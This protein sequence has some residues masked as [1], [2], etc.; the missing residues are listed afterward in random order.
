MADSSED[1]SVTVLT[2]LTDTQRLNAIINGMLKEQKEKKIYGNCYLNAASLY[3]SINLNNLGDP[4]FVVGWV[5]NK[6]EINHNALAKQQRL[7][8]LYHGLDMMDMIKKLPVFSFAAHCWVEMDGEILDA[9]YDWAGA[10]MTY[11]RDY[12]RALEEVGHCL[13]GHHRVGQLFSA[14]GFI[15][16][17]KKESARLTPSHYDKARKEALASFHGYEDYTEARKSKCILH[18][19]RFAP[20]WRPT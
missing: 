11:F 14:N 7:R 3:D 5:L 10:G 18:N 9:S 6:N 17:W 15:N 20:E 13:P 4:Q 12:N 8:G 2:V 16:G 19:E 1:E